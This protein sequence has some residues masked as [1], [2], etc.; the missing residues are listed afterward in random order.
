MSDGR[1]IHRR[2]AEDSDDY[3]GHSDGAEDKLEI[4]AGDGPAFS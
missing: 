3:L 4:V 1:M 2:M